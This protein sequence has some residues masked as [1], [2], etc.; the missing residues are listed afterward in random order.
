MWEKC[1]SFSFRSTS[2][3]VKVIVATS[4]ILIL[5][6]SFNVYWNTALHEGSI[7]KLTQEKTKIVSEFIEKN[8]IRQMEREGILRSIVF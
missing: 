2:L 1:M 5:A 3:I 4:A 6:I 8:V 7:E